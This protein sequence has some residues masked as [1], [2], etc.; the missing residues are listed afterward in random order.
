MYRNILVTGIA[1]AVV[2][3]VGYA[4]WQANAAWRGDGAGWELFAEQDA[5]EEEGEVAPAVVDPEAVEEMTVEAVPEV[6][7]EEDI[8]LVESALQVIE[9]ILVPEA[10]EAMPAAEAAPEVS[11]EQVEVAVVTASEEEEA[12]VAEAVVEAS[13]AL[14]LDEETPRFDVV[15]VEPGGSAVIAGRGAP[16]AHIILRVNGEGHAE[17]IADGRGE[18][19]MEPEHPLPVGVS[20]LSLAARLLDGRE[21]VSAQ[22]VVVTVA[23][24]EAGAAAVSPLVVL[25]EEGRASRI[26]QEPE[27]VTSAGGELSL[28]VLDYSGDG[29]LILS[30][31]AALEAAGAVVRVYLD[32]A[33]LGETRIEEDGG[34]TFRAASESIA[35]G[36]Y[37]LRI[38][39]LDEEGAVVARILQPFEQADEEALAN[40]QPDEVIV[41]P[42]NSLWR[43][44][45]QIYGR[46]IHYTIIYQANAGQIDDPHLIFPGQIFTI[47]A[48][49]SEQ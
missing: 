2:L 19:L 27:P 34:W 23:A 40:L 36:R 33:V 38:D 8:A 30:G 21:L 28:R 16:E 1:L 45:R 49:V 6:A 7:E 11:A 9:E 4:L 10:E 14:S 37:E 32:D 44:S 31:G 35:P 39:Q 43:I 26:L 46:G 15:R 22:E 47:P 41:Q 5:G 48:E 17:T 29:G 3:A 25:R 24:A 18:W 20:R 13:E 42:G 12:S